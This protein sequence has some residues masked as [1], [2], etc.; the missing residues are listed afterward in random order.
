[1][2]P[3]MEDGS[4]FVS[5]IGQDLNDIVCK[6]YERVVGN[7]NCISF[8]GRSLQIPQDGARLHYVRVKVRVHRYLDGALGIFHGPRKLATYDN[9]GR[10]LSPENKVLEHRCQRPVAP[11]SMFKV[12]ILTT[13]P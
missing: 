7:D 10:L 6:Q 1:M 8:K 2:Q 12:P 3:S 13:A 5:Y 11:T 4:A 9:K